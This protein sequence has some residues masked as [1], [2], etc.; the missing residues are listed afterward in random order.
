VGSARAEGAGREPEKC[1]SHDRDSLGVLARSGDTVPHSV[2]QQSGVG[3]RA[4]L[5]LRLDLVTREERDA[6]HSAHPLEER[7]IEDHVADAPQLD[8]LDALAEEA[9]FDL[10]PCRRS[11]RLRRL[12]KRSFT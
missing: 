11:L 4:E 8:A 12:P 3:D 7:L 2:E 6:A 9:A 1:R 10:E 5:Q